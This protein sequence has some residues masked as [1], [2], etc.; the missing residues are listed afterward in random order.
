MDKVK[1]SNTAVTENDKIVDARRKDAE[2]NLGSKVDDGDKTAAHALLPSDVEGFA[3]EHDLTTHEAGLAMEGRSREQAAKEV[4][5]IKAGRS[6]NRQVWIETPA[7]TS[8]PFEHNQQVNVVPP[9]DPS[10]LD[11]HA[12]GPQDPTGFVIR[13]DGD[14]R[15]KEVKEAGAN[16]V[17]AAD[18]A[19]EAVDEQAYEA[20][21]EDAVEVETK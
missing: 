2:K 17:E 14:S 9:P 8:S 4:D 11:V 13:E 21:K 16:Y 1:S 20:S 18:E 19:T 15:A 6:V 12:P 3:R 10:L 7:G 5:K